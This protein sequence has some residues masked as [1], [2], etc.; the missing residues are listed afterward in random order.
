MV[1]RR[2]RGKG[3]E[4]DVSH[5]R[6]HC[7]VYYTEEDRRTK[8]QIL[9]FQDVYPHG[10]KQGPQWIFLRLLEL[11][12]EWTWQL[13]QLIDQHGSLHFASTL[14][15]VK[16]AINVPA[17]KMKHDRPAPRDIGISGGGFARFPDGMLVD[18]LNR[19][20]GLSTG[21]ERL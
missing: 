21:C 10:S 7:A 13:P 17:L 14:L 15:K 19:R 4:E 6:M 5:A 1:L 2:V 3:I 9:R 18:L 11:C 12:L 16:K 8:P 20:W